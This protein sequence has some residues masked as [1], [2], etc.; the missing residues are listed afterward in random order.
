MTVLKAGLVAPE[1]QVLADSGSEVRLQCF[2]QPIVLVPD[3]GVSVVVDGL[4]TRSHKFIRQVQWRR[5]LVHGHRT[6]G[7]FGRV[8]AEQLTMVMVTDSTMLGNSA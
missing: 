5:V 3:G 7:F 6:P 4:R 2:D 8:D 1:Q